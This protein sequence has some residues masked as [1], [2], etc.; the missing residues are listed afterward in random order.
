MIEI[1]IWINFWITSLVRIIS[2]ALQTARKSPVI[3]WLVATG[4]P[5]NI[6][7]DIGIKLESN[8]FD[9]VELMKGS[10]SPRF[11]TEMGLDLEVQKQLSSYMDLKLHENI[12]SIGKFLY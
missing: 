4:V 1:L 5:Q 6:I 2:S 9:N 12:S 10:L 3:A 11:M 8:G 7:Y